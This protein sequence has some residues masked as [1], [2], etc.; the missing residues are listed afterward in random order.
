MPKCYRTD[1][2]SIRKQQNQKSGQHEDCFC[3]SQVSVE[4]WPVMPWFLKKRSL[5]LPRSRFC[6]VTQRSV[7]KQKR[8]RISVFIVTQ[9][10]IKL[11]TIQ[12]RNSR[13]QDIKEDK[14]AKGLTKNQVCAIFHMRDIGKKRFIQ[15]Y[16]AS[17]GDVL[18]VSLCGAQIWPPE[19]N[20]NIC[21]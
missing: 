7:T 21:F 19:T 2:L 10:K 13:I 3:K 6:L 17:Y 14:Y 4:L 8:L 18:F 5:Q 11:Q 12:Y 1:F 9:S 20:R 15:I 16:R